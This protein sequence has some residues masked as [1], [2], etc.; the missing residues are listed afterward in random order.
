MPLGVS[1]ARCGFK[2]CTDSEVGI[3]YKLLPGKNEFVYTNRQTGKRDCV[4]TLK[5][6]IESY[7]N[8]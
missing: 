6:R 8:F 1:V 2:F 3:S 7:G 5:I 4:W